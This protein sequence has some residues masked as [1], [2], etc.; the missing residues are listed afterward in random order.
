MI[1][2]VY[3]T[4]ILLY[5]ITHTSQMLLSPNIHTG[6]SLCLNITNHLFWNIL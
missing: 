6:V 2:Q 1:Q 3:K 5:A 4:E